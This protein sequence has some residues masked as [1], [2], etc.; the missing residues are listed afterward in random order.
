MICAARV[1]I[2]EHDARSAFP[3]AAQLEA[4]GYR[5]MRAEDLEQAKSIAGDEHPDVIIFDAGMAPQTKA[6]GDAVEAVWRPSGAPVILV[7]EGFKMN[8]VAEGILGAM[9]CVMPRDFHESQLYSR[10]ASLVRLNTMREE[11]ARRAET[12]ERY[13]VQKP[14]EIVPPNAAATMRVLVSAAQPSAR[15]RVQ[16]TFDD[17]FAIG[18]VETARAAID[19]LLAEEFEAFVL[20][21]DD[22]PAEELAI[23]AD[24][25]HNSRLYALPVVLIADSG[26]VSAAEGNPVDLV[27]DVVCR[28]F[29][30][31]DLK[32]RV[33]ALVRQRRYRR[34][35]HAVY[36]DT[37]DPMTSDALTGLFSH[38]FLHAHLARQ[39]IDAARW[40]KTL[41]LGFFDIDNMAAINA[42]HGY[43]AGDRLLRQ[44]GGIIGRLVRGEDLATRFRGD[45]FVVALPETAAE[46]AELVVQRI[47]GVVGNTE[48]AVADGYGAVNAALKFA[49]TAFA[50]GDT[51]ESLIARARTAAQVR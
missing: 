3:L 18:F 37:H 5:T 45:K 35:M 17:R 1:L 16:E 13:G 38:G 43:V 42:E 47:V 23:C 50:P 51:A 30:A 22:D 10:L 21:T 33:A 24:L 6:L 40:H 41:S 4:C 48:F 2:Y 26:G 27:D 11:I 46:V 7:A 12:S 36:A 25:R 44:V 8:G 9:T 29:G 15:A 14:R 19:R 20:A 39:I 32:A 49:V 34:K 31:G 28:P